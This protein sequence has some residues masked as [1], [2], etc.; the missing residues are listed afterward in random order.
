MVSGRA[1]LLPE[2]IR[3]GSEV[4]GKFKMLLKF[5]FGLSQNKTIYTMISFFPL[6]SHKPTIPRNDDVS[7]EETHLGWC[8]SSRRLMFLKVS[9]PQGF[10]WATEH[11][12]CLLQTPWS[13]CPQ[14]R[15][16]R[17]WPH[18]PLLDPKAF[19]HCWP[20]AP[21]PREPCLEPRYFADN[22]ICFQE[23]SSGNTTAFLSDPRKL[24]SSS[25]AEPPF[26][27]ALSAA[28]ALQPGW[29]HT[30]GKELGQKEPGVSLG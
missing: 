18:W 29:V 28:L 14:Y 2:M 9:N 5:W 12:P 8:P 3:K 1:S 20:H 15:L 26:F 4:S 7:S 27:Q 11:A 21:G 22:A 16:L 24:Q 23:N 30:A 6:I 17:P 19:S 13:L 10:Y 25:A